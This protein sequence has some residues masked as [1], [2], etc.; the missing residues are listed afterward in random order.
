MSRHAISVIAAVQKGE[1]GWLLRWSDDSVKLSHW[2][3]SVDEAMAVQMAMKKGQSFEQ[4]LKAL[5][6]TP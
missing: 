5:V 1:S 4:A 6:T 3:A 2:F